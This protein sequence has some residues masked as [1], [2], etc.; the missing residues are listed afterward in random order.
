M[1]TDELRTDDLDEI[2]EAVTITD[3]TFIQYRNYRLT[4]DGER[5]PKLAVVRC[6]DS[7][8]PG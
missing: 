2:E 3:G 5:Q 1:P 8:T 6:D 7:D 4:D